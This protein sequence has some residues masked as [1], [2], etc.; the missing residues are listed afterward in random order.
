MIAVPAGQRPAGVLRR[1]KPL[2]GTLVDIGVGAADPDLALAATQAAFAE[3]REVHRLMS[4]HEPS[5]D[6]SRINRAAPGKPIDVDPRTAEVL[7]LALEI[8]DASAGAFDCTVAPVL[9]RHGLLPPVDGREAGA[10][11]APLDEWP[12]SRGN[13]ASDRACAFAVD[14]CSVIKQ[15]DC[16]ID[17]GGIAKGCAVDRAV[18]AVV[19]LSVA[20]GHAVDSVFVNAG[21]DLRFHGRGAIAVRLRDPRDPAQLTDTVELSDGAL[22]SSSTRGLDGLARL[23]SPLVD[24]RSGAPLRMDAGATVAAPACAIADALT[25][26][27]LATGDPDHPIFARYR[28]SVVRFVANPSPPSGQR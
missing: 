25:K 15:R 14:A 24:P 9:V 22:A 27:A 21:G 16:L 17:L 18:D 28:A 13:P 5:S 2:L 7:R 1:A 11:F 12:D 20:H 26:V 8:H 23:V 4:F 10:V 3:I 6:V 19:A